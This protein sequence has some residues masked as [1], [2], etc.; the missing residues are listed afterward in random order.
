VR[1]GTPKNHQD[2]HPGDTNYKNVQAVD[3]ATNAGQAVYAVQ[4]GELLGLGLGLAAGNAFICLMIQ[5]FNPG[6]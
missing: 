6:L 3:L 4:D 1:T 5:S 2:R